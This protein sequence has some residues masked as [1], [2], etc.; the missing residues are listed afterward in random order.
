MIVVQEKL[1]P[2]R[3]LTVEAGTMGVAGPCRQGNVIGMAIHA[4]E[5]NPPAGDDSIGRTAGGRP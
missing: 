1:E 2:G 3:D 4:G 5:Y